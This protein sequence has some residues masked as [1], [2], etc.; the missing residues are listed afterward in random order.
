MKASDLGS[1]EVKSADIPVV[2]GRRDAT[3]AKGLGAGVV[4]SAR[5]SIL[6]RQRVGGI[7]TARGRYTA[8]RSAHIL[9][10]AIFR[11][12]IRSRT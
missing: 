2:A 4:G 5:I 1:A 12:G 9:V 6:T 3:D 7:D 8:I 11:R 10:V